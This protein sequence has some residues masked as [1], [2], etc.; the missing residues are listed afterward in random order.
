LQGVMM[1]SINSISCK[2]LI[3]GVCGI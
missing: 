3:E 1:D 2:I